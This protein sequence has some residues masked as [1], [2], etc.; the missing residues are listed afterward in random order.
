MADHSNTAM[1]EGCKDALHFIA[2]SFKHCKAIG[3][4]KTS[5][6]LLQIV[7][8]GDAIKSKGVITNGNA[9]AFMDAVA[10]HR[11]WEREETP[12]VAA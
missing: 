3:A 11:F 7:L 10:Q 6:S 1:L 9:K 4:T 12:V 8:P 5:S 2:E